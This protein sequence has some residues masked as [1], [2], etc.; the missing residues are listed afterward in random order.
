MNY[1]FRVVYVNRGTDL[2][3]NSREICNG[4]V[5]CKDR[6]VPPS[7]FT[8]FTTGRLRYKFIKRISS[9]KGKNIWMTLRKCEHIREE[10]RHPYKPAYVRL[11]SGL[12]FKF[13][14]KVRA[15]FQREWKNCSCSVPGIFSFFLKDSSYTFEQNLNL[16][17]DHNHTYAG[18]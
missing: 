14:L 7:P 13:C 2:E 4:I 10:N 16:K 3:R 8:T 6:T 5:N 11:W 18:L 1:C 17:P 15:I 12:R 9:V